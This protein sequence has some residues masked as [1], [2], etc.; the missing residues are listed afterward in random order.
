MKYIKSILAGSAILV[1]QS[2]GA[3]T[4]DFDNIADNNS[5]AASLDSFTGSIGAGPFFG[6]RGALSMNFSS[7]SIGLTAT[8]NEVT[9]AVINP[10]LDSGNAGLGACKV[11]TGNAQCSPSSDDN[12]TT[13][14][15]LTLTFDQ[16]VTITE[17]TFVN[18]SHGTS[19]LGTFD[20]QIDGGAVNT[21]NLTHLFAM[22]LTGTEFAFSN[23]NVNTGNKYQFYINTMEVQAV[24]VPAAAWLFGSGLLGLVGVARR[25]S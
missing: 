9:G 24:P 13:G 11:L 22:D 7:G 14:E 17:T 8:A 16:V 4:F 6:E 21:Y 3:A 25:K 23:V 1:A 18:G 5:P 19:F 2:A 15:I 10:Y 20:L 12:V